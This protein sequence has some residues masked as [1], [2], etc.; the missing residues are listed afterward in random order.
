MIYKLWNKLITTKTITT[1][2]AA[3]AIGTTV[4][5]LTIALSALGAF[6]SIDKTV[7]TAEFQNRPPLK[8]DSAI[9]SIDID[10]NSIAALGRWP[11]PL[12]RHKALI[13]L[14]KLYKG[15]C[16]IFT[17][18]DISNAA[19]NSLE[20]GEAW[21]LK[22]MI[23][24]AVLG[25]SNS[26]A[27]AL[28]DGVESGSAGF[29]NSLKAFGQVYY[30]IKFA[31]PSPIFTPKTASASSGTAL[32]LLNNRIAIPNTA[33]TI[34]E[35]AQ[36]ILPPEGILD[37]IKGGGSNIIVMDKQG[38]VLKYP[39][40]TQYNGTLYPSLA[41]NAAVRLTNADNVSI[42]P[43]KFAV[44]DSP[45]AGRV[46]I[47]IDRQGQIV[48]NWAGRYTDT[49][50]HIPWSA[51]ASFIVHQEAKNELR[52]YDLK[53]MSDPSS[54]L[55]G[56]RKELKK[57]RYAPLDQSELA[58]A[59]VYNSTLIENR[60]LSTGC[61]AKAVIDAFGLPREWMKIANQIKFNNYLL[62]KYDETER[63]PLYDEAVKELGI[64]P[65]EAADARLAESYELIMFHLENETIP[66][67][68]PL[69]FNDTPMILKDKIV[70]FG[71]T[72][73]GLISQN[74][75]PFD[76]RHPMLD[77]P[78]NV[79]NSILTGQYLRQ[80]PQPLLYA[81]IFALSYGI[82]MVVLAASPLL[83]G[84][85]A[86]FAA[87]LYAAIAWHLF[88]SRGIVMPVSQPLF[89]IAAAYISGVIYRYLKDN[90]ERRRFRQMFS[91]MVS[92]EVLKII[93]KTRGNL[94][95]GGEIKYATMFSSDLS[96]FT[97]ISEGVTPPELADIL[98]IYLTPMSNIIMCYDGYVDKYEGDAIKADFGIPLSDEGHAWKACW[99]ALYQQEELIAVARMIL[100]Q[101]GVQ[102]TARMAVNTGKVLAG[103]MGSE[104]HIQYTAMGPAVTLAEELEPANKLFGTWIMIGAQTYEKAKDYIVARCLG[105]IKTHHG[106][107]TVYELAGW[108]EEK[109]LSYWG[110]KPIPELVIKSLM[111]LRPEKILGLNYYLNNKPLTDLPIVAEIRR[112]FS[113]LSEL[114][115]QYMQIKDIINIIA[116]EEG[117][118]E[119]RKRLRHYREIYEE[120]ET[121]PVISQEIEDLHRKMADEFVPYKAVILNWIITLKIHMAHISSLTGKVEKAETEAL[122]ALADRLEK[123]V[124]TINKRIY[125]A[126]DETAE[127]ISDNLTDLLLIEDVHSSMLVEKL[128]YQCKSIER[129]ISDRLKNLTDDLKSDPSHYHRL[130]ASMCTLS[131]QRLRMFRL[132][133]DGL[134]L[135][136]QRRWDR[137]LDVFKQCLE[138][139]PQDSPSIKYTDE[140]KRLKLAPPPQDWTGAWDVS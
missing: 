122:Y 27:T 112:V 77:L 34:P 81:I 23:K 125:C 118:D 120:E 87:A 58:A 38:V 139:S 76:G 49:F 67:V 98:N 21:I 63:P 126:D 41:L 65:A 3:I 30:T 106:T 33:H 105:E 104:G 100:L 111:R 5:L 134:S 102:I 132:F 99:A 78:M 56:I 37:T 19:K 43:G 140:I 89:A 128:A 96:G 4:S 121:P 17:D 108:N 113:E 80:L 42:T 52:K 48:I 47:P 57:H 62:Q 135:F 83:G 39:L 69:Y 66:L 31:M 10:D 119:L 86:A 82:A 91:A 59:I 51:A 95:L 44:F 29:Y 90:R 123:A 7:I 133:E 15:R 9:V 114:S 107:E 75:T 71:L 116:T 20:E 138:T 130:I 68:R 137:A 127:A 18:I 25:G 53:T 28:I 124:A 129:L 84:A 11:W 101:Y 14:L 55:A 50:R 131:R 26:K 22:D 94:N 16:I 93:E 85:G 103:N 115:I 12:Y 88:K 109:F 46:E 70:F 97:T 73:T 45:K 36:V 13:D 72:A 2:L 54:A 24:E 61:T 60:L 117:I 32:T 8:T 1:L 40:V 136:K 64:T 74:P 79:L 110:N 6:N 92:P 35:A